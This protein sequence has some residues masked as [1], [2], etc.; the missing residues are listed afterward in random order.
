MCSLIKYP[1]YMDIK[2]AIFLFKFALVTIFS[3]WFYMSKYIYTAH[4]CGL[5]SKHFGD[6]IYFK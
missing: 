2:K 4:A 1:E 5:N 6:V 3:S